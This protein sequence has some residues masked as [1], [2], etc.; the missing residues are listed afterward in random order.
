[1]IH[2]TLLPEDEARKLKFEYH[3]RIVIVLLLF[4]SF[5]VLVGVVSLFPAYVVFSSQE[6]ELNEK[7]IE[8][9]KS[10]AARG[11]DLVIKEMNDSEGLLNALKK[12]D[13]NTNL[14]S[15]I[16]QAV[17]TKNPSINFNS[18]QVSKVTDSAYAYEIILQGK[19]STRE[20]LLLYKKSLER[21]L[22]FVKI[23]FPIPDLTKSRDVSFAVKIKLNKTK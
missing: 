16:V 14:S 22:A 23:E 8:V 17:N 18:I 13:Q 1:M 15:L 11:I 5:S 6:N 20:D 12:L 21:N 10:K 9:K 19:S 7:L 3:I 4:I 2:Y